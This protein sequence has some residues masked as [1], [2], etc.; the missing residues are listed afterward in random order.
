MEGPTGGTLRRNDLIQPLPDRNTTAT[1]VDKLQRIQRRCPSRA[2]VVEKT[3]QQSGG[4]DVLYI[5]QQRVRALLAVTGAA[6]TPVQANPSITVLI[7]PS[8]GFQRGG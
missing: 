5:P 2:V 7:D 8:V 6:I 1:L 3:H 4:D